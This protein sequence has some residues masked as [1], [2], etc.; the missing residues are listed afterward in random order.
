VPKFLRALFVLLFVATAVYAVRPL[1]S[2][3]PPLCYDLP[4]C[5]SPDGSFTYSHECIKDGYVVYVWVQPS[6]DW[7]LYGPI[8]P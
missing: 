4:T 5:Q 6:G 3:P 8:L 7:C 1:E 2:P